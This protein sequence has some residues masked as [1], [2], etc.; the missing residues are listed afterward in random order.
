MGRRPVTRE[1]QL[2]RSDTKPDTKPALL[3]TVT[4]QVTGTSDPKEAERK[5][6]DL[7]FAQTWC[8]RVR[9]AVADDKHPVTW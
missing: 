3:V 7:L 5:V 1:N 8:K 6:T 4:V 9:A 2:E